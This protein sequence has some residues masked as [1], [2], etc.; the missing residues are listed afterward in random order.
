TID[1][2]RLLSLRGCNEVVPLTVVLVQRRY[3]IPGR[4]VVDPP[5]AVDHGPQVGSAVKAISQQ[6]S[7]HGN[8]SN[9]EL[10]P[11][12]IPTHDKGSVLRAEEI[13]PTRPGHLRDGEVGWQ[14]AVRRQFARSDTSHAW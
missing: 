8:V 3:R 5:H 10:F 7:R 1:V 2:K 13:R 12:R 11:I 14:G 9:A 6:V 4:L